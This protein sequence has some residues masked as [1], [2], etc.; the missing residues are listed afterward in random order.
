MWL[1]LLQHH[2]MFVFP[3]FFVPTGSFR[4]NLHLLCWWLII[5]LKWIMVWK[6]WLFNSC[7][8]TR[9]ASH[10]SCSTTTTWGPKTCKC[11]LTSSPVAMRPSP[12][13]CCWSWCPLGGST[14]KH[15]AATCCGPLLRTSRLWPVMNAVWDAAA[16]DSVAL[17]PRRPACLSEQATSKEKI[18]VLKKN[19][20]RQMNTP[21]FVERNISFWWRKRWGTLMTLTNISKCLFFLFFLIPRQNIWSVGF[22]Q[23]EEKVSE[24]YPIM[25][26]FHSLCNTK[27]HFFCL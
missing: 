15:V 8:R 1:N 21:L 10:Q 4:M 18:I 3:C 22:L 2:I 5:W 6:H 11:P 24:D 26:F 25:C 19:K 14:C 20:K 13:R 7:P 17:Q 12:H 23:F 27:G 16:V 9:R